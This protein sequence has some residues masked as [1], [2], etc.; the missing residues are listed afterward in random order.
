MRL[1]LLSACLVASVTRAQVPVPVPLTPGQTAVLVGVGASCGTAAAALAA[2]PVADWAPIDEIAVLVVGGALTGGT[3]ACVW[4]LGRR[5]GHG[6]RFA[7]TLGDAAQGVGLGLLG[8]IGVGYVVYHAAGGERSGYGETAFFNDALIA[9][10]LAAG[11][12][13]LVTPAVV[14]A[15]RLPRHTPVAVAPA[16]VAAPD[17]TRVPGMALRVGL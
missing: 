7:S 6:G 11:A 9:A 15:L 13:T 8:G 10:L 16:T 3:A 5:V 14:S 4:G 1:L 12:T 2:A 17:G